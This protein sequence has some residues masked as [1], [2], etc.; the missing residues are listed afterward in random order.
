MAMWNRE[1][2]NSAAEPRLETYR[3]WR[4]NFGGDADEDADF[5]QNFYGFGFDGN[6]KKSDKVGNSMKLLSGMQDFID[7]NQQKYT[8]EEWEKLKKFFYCNRAIIAYGNSQQNVLVN[9]TENSAFYSGVKHCNN[10]FACPVCSFKIM[11]KRSDEIDKVID[12]AYEGRNVLGKKLQVLMVTFTVQHTKGMP[13]D[14]VVRLGKMTMKKFKSTGLRFKGNKF[15]FADV[16][17]GFGE[18]GVIH[19]ITSWE[20]TYGINGL[21]WHSHQIWFVEDADDFTEELE[22]ECKKRW[23]ACYKKALAELG[24]NMMVKE[25]AFLERGFVASRDKK[26]GKMIRI[27]SGKYL[28][29]FGGG[30]E[31]SSV[32]SKDAKNGNRNMFELLAS[33]SEEDKKIF[34][35]F[36]IA[37]HGLTRVKFS[38]GLRKF[39]LMDEE[40]EKTDAELGNEEV[41]AEAVAVIEKENWYEV[42][43]AEVTGRVQYARAEIL[44]IAY[45]QGY[46]GLSW[47]CLQNFDFIPRTAYGYVEVRKYFRVKVLDDENNE[48]EVLQSE[49]IAKIEEEDWRKVLHFEKLGRVPDAHN[50]IFEVAFTRGYDALVN[51]CLENF[52]FIPIASEET[53]RKM[54]DEMTGGAGCVFG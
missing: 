31:L 41:L 19:T 44:N 23:L 4:L 26:T 51:Y 22:R 1:E 24:V 32:I 17:A 35:E 13:Q 6:S 36:A 21:H 25:E 29:G 20:G 10:A 18:L 34:M 12:K 16:S 2:K 48:V 30:S 39:F 53:R 15:T 50:Q 40:E 37:T 5:R 52:G 42:L 9:R 7:E 43:E 8:V 54:E 27:H 3:S 47:Y 49:L 14:E 28:C 45:N 38:K 46:R 11:T 33:D